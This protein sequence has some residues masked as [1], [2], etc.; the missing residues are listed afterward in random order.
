VL[1]FVPVFVWSRASGGRAAPPHPPRHAAHP[2][3]HATGS[4]ARLVSTPAPPPLKATSSSRLPAHTNVRTLYGQAGAAEGDGGGRGFGG[5]TA[6][7]PGR[8]FFPKLTSGP[9]IIPPPANRTGLPRNTTRLHGASDHDHP[10]AAC[11]RAVVRSSR[12]TDSFTAGQP[13]EAPP[14]SKAHC[15]PRRALC[16][17][18]AL[19]TP[20]T[21]QAEHEGQQQWRNGRR[22]R[23][24]CCCSS[25]SA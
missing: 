23:C 5:D 16:T 2:R 11:G 9:S 8:P 18:S 25:C 17:E 14:H 21:R 19:H 22:P 12:L 7:Q 4:P 10:K 15:F 20:A 1:E 3:S 6:K 13:H 24:R